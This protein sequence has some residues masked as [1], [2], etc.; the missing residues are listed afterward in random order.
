MHEAE[1]SLTLTHQSTLRQNCQQIEKM[2]HCH[3]SLVR[4]EHPLS[5]QKAPTCAMLTEVKENPRLTAKDMQKDLE[6]VEISYV[7]TIKKKHWKMF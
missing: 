1:K 5:V 4:C 2:S 6:P 7:S 3:Y